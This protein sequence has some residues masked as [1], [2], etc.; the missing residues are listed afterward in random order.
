MPCL[1]EQP[2]FESPRDFRGRMLKLVERRGL[3]NLAG[4]Q[5]TY[6]QRLAHVIE[7]ILL[8]VASRLRKNVVSER[9][10]DVSDMFHR[11]RRA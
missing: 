9:R 8:R 1:H 2:D 4:I 3:V 11:A 6:R 10:I 7:I 5:S